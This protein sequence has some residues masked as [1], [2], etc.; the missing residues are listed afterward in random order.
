MSNIEMVKPQPTKENPVTVENYPYGFRLRTKAQYWVETVEGKG[1][2]IGFRTL[3][4]KTQQWNKP[5]LS[6][7]S[8]ILVLFR[9]LENG[10]IEND[11]LSFT[12]AGQMQLEKFLERFRESDLTDYQKKQLIFFRAIIRTRE[13]VKV[14][15]VVDPSEKEQKRIDENNKK[16]DADLKK[17]LTSYYIDE[18]KKAE[19]AEK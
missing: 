11:G 16:V 6:T 15:I 14:N 19:G 8:D 1:Q 7:Y 12:Y 13:H 9:N 18:K 17:I 2:R 3:N 5:K 10:H 4:P